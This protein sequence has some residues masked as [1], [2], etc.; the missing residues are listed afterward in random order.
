M[1]SSLAPDPAHIQKAYDDQATEYNALL[2]MPFGVMEAQLVSNALRENGLC[3]EAKLLDLGGGTGMRAAQAIQLGAAKVDIVDISSEMMAEG[4]RYVKRELAPDQTANIQ[5]LLGDASKSLFDQT[6]GVTRLGKQ[7]TYDIVMG[8]W[9]FDHVSDITVL[10]AMWHNISR[11]L[12][13]GGRFIG[14][15]A[16]DPRT[17]AMTTGKYGPTCQDF[18]EFPGGLFYSSTI[19]ANPDVHLDNAS[20]WVSYSGSTEMHE[21]YGLG[22]VSVEPPEETEVAKSDPDFW[23]LWIEQPGF[24]V[25]KATKLVTLNADG[26]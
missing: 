26:A 3:E 5:W 7:G 15:R 9:I 8:N 25:V 17:P 12:R 22:E 14:V 16:C 19:P 21:K 20:L 10:E 18:K 23:R 6:D 24:A 11:A 13:P 2:G 4:K 1:A